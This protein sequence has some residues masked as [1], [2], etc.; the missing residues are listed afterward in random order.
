[1]PRRAS[2]E[3]TIYRRLD[4]RWVAQLSLSGGKRKTFYGLSQREVRDKLLVTRRAAQK[5]LLPTGPSQTVA[6]FCAHWL[7][8]VVK[9]SVRPKT[10]ESYGL[11]VRRL[12]PYLASASWR[13]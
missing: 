10:Y 7:E 4:G 12:M 2:G 3:G 1:M 5:G 11:N 13:T 6:D 8:D 9:P